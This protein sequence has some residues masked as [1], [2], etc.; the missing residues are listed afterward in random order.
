[1]PARADVA[2]AERLGH[3]E[4]GVG[5]DPEAHPKSRRKLS[6]LGRIVWRNRNGVSARLT[7]LVVEGQPYPAGGN[8]HKRRDPRRLATGITLHQPSRG[9]TQG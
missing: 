2:Y 3:R 4:V 7:E 9:P 6:V 1:M 5:Q 8:F